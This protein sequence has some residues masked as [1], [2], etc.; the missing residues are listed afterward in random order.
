MKCRLCEKYEWDDPQEVLEGK[1]YCVFHAP[2]DEKGINGDAFKHHFRA[3]I[4][5]V[6][7]GRPS[8][9]RLNVSGIIVPDGAGF[10][11]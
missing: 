2:V 1:D 3:A 9:I 4:I 7:G 5:E 11:Q 8:S 6:Y 10:I